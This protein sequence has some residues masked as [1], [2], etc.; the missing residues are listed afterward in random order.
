MSIFKPD[1]CNCC[2]KEI[3][4]ENWHYNFDIGVKICD[5]CF[6]SLKE[7]EKKIYNDKTSSKEIVFATLELAR[8][9]T[10]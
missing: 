4:Q 5:N 10:E 3:P 8:L 6:N 9:R 1:L 7:S 2:L